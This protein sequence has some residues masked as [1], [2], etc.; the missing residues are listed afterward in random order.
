MK[1]LKRFN[2]EL[3]PRTYLSAAKKLTAIGHTDRANTLKDWANETEKREEIIKWKERIQEY[4]PFGIYKVNIVN[5]QSGEMFTADF[6]LDLSFDELA[7]E[8]SFEYEKQK[9]PNNINGVNIFFFIGL[10]PTSEEVLKK[11]EEVM[12]ESEFGNGMFWGMCCGVDFKVQ[13]GEVI[14]DKFTL[15][16]YDETLSGNISFAD[17]ASAAKFKNLLKSIFSNPELNY[18]SGYRDI[19]YIYQKLEQVILIQ[20]GFSSDYG[21]EL[22]NVGDFINTQSPNTM[23]KT[24]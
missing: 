12:P 11:C 15:D 23:Y 17:R 9:D 3:R 20:Q 13:N 18:P 16:D 4:S 7:F 14:L 6:A 1:Y 8:D 22:K 21:F 2:E 5:P 19:E 10:I 24:I